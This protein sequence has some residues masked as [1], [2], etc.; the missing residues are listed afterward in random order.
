ME[1]KKKTLS[2]N[3]LSQYKSEIYGLSILWIML[4]HSYLS[5]V[6]FFKDEPVLRYIG[7]IICY[8]NMGVEVFLLLSGVCLYFSYIKNPSPVSFMKKRLVRL[9]PSVIVIRGGFWLWQYFQGKITLSR[10]LFS[11]TTLRFWFTGDGEIWF[12][13]LI[14]LCYTMYP[15]IYGYLFEKEEG[16]TRRFLLLFFVVVGFTFLARASDPSDYA[17]IEIGLTRIPVF[18]IGCWLGK[19]VY[20]KKEISRCWWPVFAIMAL[21]CFV[22]LEQGILEDIYKRYFYMVGGVSMTFLFAGFS[23]CAGKTIRKILTFFGGISLELYLAHL[24]VRKMNV[25]GL[26]FSYE[27][28]HTKKYLLV[29]V[30][31]VGVAWVAS[32]LID[33]L[34]K[35]VRLNKKKL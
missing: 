19:Y 28:G 29:L 24:M 12:I 7:R 32:R 18:L 33:F 25:A 31:S 10:A 21:L 2:L 22:V 30:I 26:L 14:L 17:R 16:T 35:N 1:N 13:P 34:R 3:I 9:I 4:F 5:D 6:Y 11:M 23:A 8:G 27:P 15:Y 20:E